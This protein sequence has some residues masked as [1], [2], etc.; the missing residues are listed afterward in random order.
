MRNTPRERQNVMRNLAKKLDNTKVD[1][2][3]KE[4]IPLFVD[5]LSFHA[6]R[7]NT[8]SIRQKKGLKK[9]YKP[10]IKQIRL[11]KPGPSKHPTSLDT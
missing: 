9:I 8:L 2:S 7:I 1:K 6:A 10:F 11:K 5:A 4:K 3:Y